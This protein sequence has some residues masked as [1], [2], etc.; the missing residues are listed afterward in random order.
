MVSIAGAVEQAT[1]AL[2]GAT[3]AVCAGLGKEL[4]PVGF[5][6]ALLHAF[7]GFGIEQARHRR[8]AALAGQTGDPHLPQRAAV[9]DVE[10]VADMEVT[11]WLATLAIEAHL[12]AVDSVGC[13]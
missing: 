5:L 13:Q 2:G 1:V 4:A 6:H 7:I 12:A 3:F 10:Q 9:I 8:R 11:R